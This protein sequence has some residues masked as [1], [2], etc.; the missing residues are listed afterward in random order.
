LAANT[1]T[2]SKRQNHRLDAIQQRE[3]RR[4]GQRPG[5]QAPGGG[6]QLAAAPQHIRP[7][8]PEAGEQEGQR[9]PAG[10]G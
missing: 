7:D 4:A 2:V 1:G 8:H 9:W 6:A 5:D 3:R 10:L